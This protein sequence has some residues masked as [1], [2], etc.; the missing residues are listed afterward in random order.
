MTDVPQKPKPVA[1]FPVKVQINVAGRTEPKEESSEINEN[2]PSA[3]P[4]IL[5]E[6]PKV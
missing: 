5:L 1:F 2:E 4:L 3:S 6:S